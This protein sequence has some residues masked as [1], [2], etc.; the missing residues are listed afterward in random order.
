MR[1]KEKDGRRG[2]EMGFVWG[3]EAAE[4]VEQGKRLVRRGESMEASPARV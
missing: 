4:S 1:E 3:D 2:N